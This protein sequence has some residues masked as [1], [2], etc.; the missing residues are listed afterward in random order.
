MPEGVVYVGRPSVWGNPWVLGDPAIGTRP[1]GSA[2]GIDDVV[3]WFRGYALQRAAADAQW[4]DPL[5]GMDL[6]C[7]CPLE[8]EHGNPWP[9]HADVLLQMANR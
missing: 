3:R 5:R 7:W 9:C 2:W 6:A 4:L 8:D 1:D